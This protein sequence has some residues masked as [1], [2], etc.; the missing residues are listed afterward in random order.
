MCVSVIII[1]H[2][3]TAYHFFLF[4]SLF[5]ASDPAQ[6]SEE[7]VVQAGNYCYPLMPPALSD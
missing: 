2:Y 3:Y 6:I 5:S 7:P 1:H 4:P